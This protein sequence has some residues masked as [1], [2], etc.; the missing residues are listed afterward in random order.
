VRRQTRIFRNLHYRW[1]FAGLVL[2]DIAIITLPA[3]ML[4]VPVTVLGF[5]LSWVIVLA[6]A[7]ALTLIIVKRNKPPGY[8]EA[9]IAIYTTPPRFSHKERDRIVRP[10]PLPPNVLAPRAAAKRTVSAET[11]R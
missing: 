2:E 9:Q 4:V 7:T 8:V 10:F 3:S 5:S 11:V 6:A 1:T